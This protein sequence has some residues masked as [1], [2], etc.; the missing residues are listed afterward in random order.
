MRTQSPFLAN[1]CDLN[2]YKKKI[3]KKNFKK[4]KNQLHTANNKTYTRFFFLWII[5]DYLKTNHFIFSCNSEI[6]LE[7]KEKR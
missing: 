1:A 2:A 5:I 7:K 4:K 6:I 3:S